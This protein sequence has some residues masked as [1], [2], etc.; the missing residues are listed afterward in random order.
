MVPVE[1]PQPS[2]Q[3]EPLGVCFRCHA[4]RE[5][6]TLILNVIHVILS[7][8]NSTFNNGSQDP[9]KS[10]RQL[11]HAAC[12]GLSESRAGCSPYSPPRRV[13]V[14]L[15]VQVIY[16]TKPPADVPH[17][18]PAPS[19]PCRWALAQAPGWAGSSAG[20]PLPSRHDRTTVSDPVVSA[21]RPG[22]VVGQSPGRGNGRRGNGVCSLRFTVFRSCMFLTNLSKNGSNL[23]KVTLRNFETIKMQ[24][25]KNERKEQWRGHLLMPPHIVFSLGKREQTA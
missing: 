10:N 2:G 25:K 6:I 23:I 1:C 15:R 21:G 14:A 17:V 20:P 7:L 9:W 4:T 3:L 18:S 12:P 22:P 19:G 8:C 13:H 16:F 5:F 11:L 24:G